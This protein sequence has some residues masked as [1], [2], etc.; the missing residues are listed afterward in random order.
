MKDMARIPLKR[1]Q[2]TKFYHIIRLFSVGLKVWT[3]LSDLLQFHPFPRWTT[4]TEKCLGSKNQMAFFQHI[5]LKYTENQHPLLLFCYH[6]KMTFP[7]QW[8]SWWSFDHHTLSMT[9]NFNLELYFNN[10]T[11]FPLLILATCLFISSSEF[12]HQLLLLKLPECQVQ[13]SAVNVYKH[14]S[15]SIKKIAFIW[16]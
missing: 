6:S 14:S 15:F 7:T 16:S 3:P 1:H 5:R 11:F 8:L 13:E 2:K 9:S 12:D 4:A 10:T